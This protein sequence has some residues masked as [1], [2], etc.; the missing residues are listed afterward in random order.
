M[1]SINPVFV[2]PGALQDRGAEIASVLT[3]SVTFGIGQF[4]TSPGVL[5]ALDDPA[6][7]QFVEAAKSKFADTNPATMVHAGIRNAFSNGLDALEN[8]PGVSRIATSSTGPDPGK[9]E[10]APTLFLTDSATFRGDET[11]RREN[12]GPSSV[13]VTCT[14][15]EDLLEIARQM[16][17]NLTATIQGNDADFVE[18]A[19]LIEILKTKVGRI[20][21]NGVP[22][23]LEV[24]PSIQHGGPYPACTLDNATSVGSEAIKR[25]ARPIAFQGAPDSALPPE[26]QESNP[27]GIRR[28]VDGTWE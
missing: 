14:S 16:D 23:G 7:D 13:V 24:C 26:L 25:F 12:F 1:G 21:F 5:V 17:G 22:T 10:G 6:T 2:L 18:Y 19:E 20:L 3:D 28:L 4:C 27:L 11:L 8:A 9:T 15:K